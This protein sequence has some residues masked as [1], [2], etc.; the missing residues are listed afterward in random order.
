MNCLGRSGIV[1]AVRSICCFTVSREDETM[2]FVMVADS[3]VTVPVATGGVGFA[4][5]FS[6]HVFTSGS[7]SSW[8]NWSTFA[9][10]VG[11]AAGA[12]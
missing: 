9:G 12:L 1:L 8:I 5:S 6:S 11:S 2:D 10:V 4:S 3:D 7:D